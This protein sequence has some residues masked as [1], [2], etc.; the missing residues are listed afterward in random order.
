MS[1]PWE[2]CI[3]R[4]SGLCPECQEEYDT[5]FAAWIEFGYH[6]EGCRRWEEELQRQAAWDAERERQRVNRPPVDDS[7]IPF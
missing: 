6:P 1:A 4:D 5:D 3:H 2:T 7:D